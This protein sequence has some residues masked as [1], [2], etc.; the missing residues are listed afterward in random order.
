MKL[1]EE[2]ADLELLMARFKKKSSKQTATKFNEKG[3]IL[4]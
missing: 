3:S 2:K 1:E 4:Q